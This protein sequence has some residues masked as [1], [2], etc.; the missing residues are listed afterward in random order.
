MK[1][2]EITIPNL[3]ASSPTTTI[4]FKAASPTQ[5]IRVGV[6]SGLNI[7]SLITYMPS[8]EQCPNIPT[9][10]VPTLIVGMLGARSSSYRNPKKNNLFF[11]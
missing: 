1:W 5:I 11:I 10:A 2:D 4:K 3:K 8:R 7:E 9:M 6:A